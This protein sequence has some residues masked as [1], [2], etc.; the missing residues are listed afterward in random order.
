[1]S[2]PSS[3]LMSSNKK[4]LPAA[5]FISIILKLKY[6]NVLLCVFPSFRCPSLLVVGDNS[7]A[8]EAVVS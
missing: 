7:P 5:Y 4:T 3:K 6:S 8:V 2:E 1:M